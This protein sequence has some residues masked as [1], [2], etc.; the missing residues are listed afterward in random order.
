MENPSQPEQKPVA[1][2]LERR[3]EEKG[4]RPRFAAAVIATSWG[5]AIVVFGIV[6]H[7]IDPDAFENVWLGMWWAT[8][9]VTTVGY[10]DTIPNSTAGDLVAVLL[11]IGGL[12]LFS[13]VTGVVTSEFVARAQARRGSGGDKR[14]ELKL[15]QL[16]ADLKAV[17]EQLTRIVGTEETPPNPPGGS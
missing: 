7:L 13:V 8:Q 4:L 9:T 12:S 15:D 3:V 11:M 16:A 2:Y 1:H 5:L 10:G 17:R 14:Q 6:Q